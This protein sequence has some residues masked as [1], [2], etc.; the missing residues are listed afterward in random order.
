M[1]QVHAT[2]APQHI[3]EVDY[4]PNGPITLNGEPFDWDLARLGAGRYHILYRGHSYNAELV[5]ADY[6]AK[7]I[8]LTL[9]GQRLE[10]Q[11]KDRFDLLLDKMGLTAVASSKV[12]ELKAPMPGLIVDI[13]VTPGQTV[14]KGDPLLVLEAMK[15]ENILKAPGEGIVTAIKINLRDNVTK[16]QVLVQFS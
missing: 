1:L 16:G 2:T 6:V 3:W 4:Q 5:E 12:N 11:A 15:M 14:Q 10:L 8:V 9:N 13:R 7:T